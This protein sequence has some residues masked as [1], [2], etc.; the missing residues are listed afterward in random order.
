M[1][2]QIIPQTTISDVFYN[3]F[4][5]TVRR[6]VPAGGRLLNPIQ[7]RRQ[8]RALRHALKNAHIEFSGRHPQWAV[9]LFDKHFLA[10]GA[11]PILER[12]HTSA[13]LP[14]PRDLANAWAD[15]LQLSPETRRNLVNE[16]TPIAADFLRLLR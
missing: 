1:T 13:V 4:P 14:D 6:W 2:R 9:A 16:L 10:H 11:S 7:Q 3:I 8:R 15:Q 5:A 12:Y